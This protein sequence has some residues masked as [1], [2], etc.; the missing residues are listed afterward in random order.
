MTKWRR[1]KKERRKRMNKKKMTRF[2][3][4]SNTRRWREWNRRRRK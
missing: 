1:R 2:G 3:S 4:R